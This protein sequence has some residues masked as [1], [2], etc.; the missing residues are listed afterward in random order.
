MWGPFPKSVFL[1]DMETYPPRIGRS[2]VGKSR[3]TYSQYGKGRLWNGTSHNFPLTAPSTIIDPI[4]SATGKDEIVQSQGNQY[5]FLGRSNRRIGGNFTVI[6][7]VLVDNIPVPHLEHSNVPG[8]PLAP[9]S[10]FHYS[11][12]L[13]AGGVTGVNDWPSAQILSAAELDAL[14]TSII[15]GILPT[16]PLSGALVALGELRSEGL[17]TVPI[18]GSWRDRTRIA[19]S[20]GN[21]YLNHQ[22]GWVPLVNDLKA[23]SNVVSNHDDLVKQYERNSGRRIKRRVTFPIETTVVSETKT[24]AKLSPN[25]PSSIYVSGTDVRTKTDKKIVRHWFSGAFTYYLP[26]YVKNGDNSK[27]NRQLRNYL[28][29]TRVTPE[30][31]WDL[32]PWTWAADWVGNFGDVLHNISAFHN[33]GLVMQY[34]YIMSQQIHDVTYTWDGVEFKTYPGHKYVAS[35][36]YRTIVKQRRVATPYG[37][38][39]DTGLFTDRQWSILAALGITRGSRSLD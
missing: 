23:F 30:V 38:G 36:T 18:L 34:G 10:G 20:A 39:L 1:A 16:N 7:R 6:K 37:F 13:F 14:G 12:P 4:F 32:T 28:Y 2:F 24:N 15:A 11:G 17:P 35:V 3:Y 19:R 26:P 5:Q 8:Q 29:G 31:I 22:F 9:G 21:E 27:R 33:D 25:P